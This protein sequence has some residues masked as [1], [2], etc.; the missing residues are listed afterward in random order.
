M[1]KVLIS[2]LCVVTLAACAQPG[3]QG[4]APPG[5]VGLNK[6]TGGAL[7][8]A[9]LGGLA[10]SQLGHGSGKLAT[11]ALGVVLGGLLGGSVGASLDRA[12]QTALNQSTQNALESA[13]T[14]QPVQWRNPDNG[15]Y[16]TVVP[17]RT[18]QPS[19]GQYCREFQQTV[20]IGGQSQQAYG[21]ACRQP[22]GTWQIQQS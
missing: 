22:D 17:V 5:E 18:Y 7:V 8:G 10:G 20:V 12:D 19:P 13:P 4:Y 14:N 15:H 16:G 21:T 11:T 3:Q 9:G 6:T 2:A 1:R